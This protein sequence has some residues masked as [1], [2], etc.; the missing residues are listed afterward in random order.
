MSPGRRA[1][2]EQHVQQAG[3]VAYR[4]HDRYVADGLSRGA[5]VRDADVHEPPGQSR[6]RSVRHSEPAWFEY[7]DRRHAK[8]QQPGG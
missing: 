6:R 3:P 5:R 7:S 1:G 8:P 4:D 2:S